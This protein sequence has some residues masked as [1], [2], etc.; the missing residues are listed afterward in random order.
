MTE[1]RRGHGAT[2]LAR[3]LPRI[4]GKALRRRGFVETAVV[5]RWADIVGDALARDAAP[6]RIRFPRGRHAGG[7]LH[8]R[9]D[10]ASALELQH[11]APVIVERVNAFFG[12]PAVARLAL[13]QAPLPPRD[14]PAPRRVPA[15]LDAGSEAALAGEV[16]GVADD[17][18]R[19]ALLRL[20][21]AIRS[22][23]GRR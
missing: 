3:L 7:V 22:Q 10:G 23:G 4:A 13:V 8:V 21:R 2:A 14:E 18:L 11:Q 16:D 20:G 12:Y 15:A 19:A 6:E 5:T 9:V 17:G 1:D